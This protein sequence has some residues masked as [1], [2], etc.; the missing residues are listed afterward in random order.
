MSNAGGTAEEFRDK[1]LDTFE[2][3]KTLLKGTL[4]TFGVALGEPFAA[5]FKPIVKVIVAVLNGLLKVFNAIPKPIKTFFA[6]LITAF[7]AILAVSG[8]ALLLK[9]VISLVLIVVKALGVTL[10]GLIAAAWPVVLAIAALIAVIQT[11]KIAYERNL[12]GFADF[13]K[14]TYEK[15][16]LFWNALGQLFSQ[17]GF[18]GKVKDELLN[19][20]NQGL[21]RFVITVWRII[22]RLKDAWRGLSEGFTETLDELK[23]TFNLFT[24]AFKEIADEVGKLFGD[25]GEAASGSRFEGLKTF[26]KYLGK[27]AAKFI[28]FI[29][30]IITY[31]AKVVSGIVAGFSAVKS[32]IAPYIEILKNAFGD[33]VKIIRGLF[34]TTDKAGN[35]VSSLG[36]VFHFLGKIL[37][38]IISYIIKAILL[39]LTVVIR[40]VGAIVFIGGK[41]YQF[42]RWIICGI[43]DIASSIGEAVSS[44][45]NVIFDL[46]NLVWPKIV[47]FLKNIFNFYASIVKGI[48]DAFL[49]IW[50]F[51][52]GIVNKVAS[53]ISNALRRA[54]D[55]LLEFVRKVLR[56]IPDTF[57][58]ESLIK[59]RDGSISSEHKEKLSIESGQNG[60]MP[61]VAAQSASKNNFSAMMREFSDI[62]AKSKDKKEQNINIKLEVDGETLASATHKAGEENANRSLSPVPTY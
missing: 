40:V 3:Q 38:V 54:I 43:I 51:I 44:V 5:V 22:E 8:G 53:T 20:E 36:E 58:P 62:G 34:G 50:D 17:G 14:K 23:P 30:I 32:T 4:Q 60:A 49:G 45:I 11:F 12:G 61:A 28:G 7:G 48:R 16:K 46:I 24:E 47:G 52:V 39:V 41:I 59:F 2:G 42:F 6:A 15:V 10:G 9:G 1:M 37:G 33:L 25:L 56:K 21:K 13:V 27:A 18:S 31:A 29:A 57:L 35:K 26:L 19:A 55:S